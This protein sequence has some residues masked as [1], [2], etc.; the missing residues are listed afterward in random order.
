MKIIQIIWDL[1]T[2]KH[3]LITASG[4][5]IRLTPQKLKD[6]PLGILTKRK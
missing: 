4:R 5:E 2:G 6:M 3:V 1:K